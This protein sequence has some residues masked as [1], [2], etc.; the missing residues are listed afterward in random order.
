LAQKEHY[1]TVEGP[2]G[3]ADIFEL[4]AE[5]YSPEGQP[6]FEP[7]YEVVYQ[8]KSEVFKSEGEAITAAQ[9]LVGAESRY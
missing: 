1:F 4:T 5:A 2:K 6:S 9:Q 7:S 8:N 3:K